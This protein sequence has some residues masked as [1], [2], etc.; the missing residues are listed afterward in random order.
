MSLFDRVFRRKMMSCSQVAAVLQEYLDEE[1][2]PGQVPKVLAH[3]EACRHCGLEASAY[4]RI[5]QSLLAHQH[6]PDAESMNRIRAFADELATSGL[7][8][9][10]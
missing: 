3:L 5:K 1:L 10:D 6:A 7:P 4:R 2:D 9:T 8:T